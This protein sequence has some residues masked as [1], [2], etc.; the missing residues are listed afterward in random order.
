MK[1]KNIF[2]YFGLA[3]LITTSLIIYS[4]QKENSGIDKSVNQT[5]QSLKDSQLENGLLH[6]ETK[7][8]LSVKTQP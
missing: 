4:C 6:L 3:T 2:T 7:L 5:E 8:T 1:W